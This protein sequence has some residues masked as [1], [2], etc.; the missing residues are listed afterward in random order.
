MY[1]SQKSDIVFNES[2]MHRQ[3]IKEVKVRKVVFKHVIPSI[4]IKQHIST[5]LDPS[6][7][8]QP[9]KNVANQH[10]DAQNDDSQHDVSHAQPKHIQSQESLVSK[11]LGKF[12]NFVMLADFGERSC[13]HEAIIVHDHCKWQHA[14]HRDLGS[15]HKIET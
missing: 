12:T 10:D 5:N 11:P 8:A 3:P 15:I 6:M 2:R 7:C 9:C 13:Y 1:Q 14:M 4:D